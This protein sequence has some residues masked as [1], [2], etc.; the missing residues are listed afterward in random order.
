MLSSLLMLATFAVGIGSVF[1]CLG[2]AAKD[3]ELRKHLR[4]EL[5]MEDE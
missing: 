3:P 5:N 2:L 1:G 4:K